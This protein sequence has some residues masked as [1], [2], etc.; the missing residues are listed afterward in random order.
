MINHIFISFF[1][2]QIYGVSYIHY[3][4]GINIPASLRMVFDFTVSLTRHESII[5]LAHGIV[6]SLF[7]TQCLR[8]SD[9]QV[10]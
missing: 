9:K 10:R 7:V 1:A 3:L 6:E 2:V 8:I 4:V 5:S